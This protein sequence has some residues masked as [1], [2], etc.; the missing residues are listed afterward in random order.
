MKQRHNP[1]TGKW[2]LTRLVKREIEYNGGEMPVEDLLNQMS[3]RGYFKESVR[4]R[5]ES[6]EVEVTDGKARVRRC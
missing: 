3:R 5:L 2:T 4:Q 6:L 1:T